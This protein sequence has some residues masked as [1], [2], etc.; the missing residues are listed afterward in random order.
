MTPSR[1]RDP[2]QTNASGVRSELEKLTA[3]PVDAFERARQHDLDSGNP[4]FLAEEDSKIA[5]GQAIREAMSVR[6]INV[7]TLHE[8]TGLPCDV[9]EALMNGTGDIS[10]SDPIQRLEAA[11]RTRL[12][13]L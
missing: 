10:D 12:T 13:H 11:L 7:Y 9:I 6:E 4:F 1:D 5:I 8:K 2:R 3:I